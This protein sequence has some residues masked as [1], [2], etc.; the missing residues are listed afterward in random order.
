[1]V[2]Y[3]FTMFY[4]HITYLKPASNWMRLSRSGCDESYSLLTLARLWSLLIPAFFHEWITHVTPSKISGLNGK[5]NDKSL[6]IKGSIFSNNPKIWSNML[7]IS[8]SHWGN[9]KQPHLPMFKILVQAQSFWLDS[10]SRPQSRCFIIPNMVQHENYGWNML[11][12]PN[13]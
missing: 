11:K 3:R 4:P 7:S 12:P 1:M 5:H 10:A 9:V 13:I 6:Q 2:Y 8:F